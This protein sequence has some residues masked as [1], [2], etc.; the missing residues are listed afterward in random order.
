MTITT[1][2]LRALLRAAVLFTAVCIAVLVSS[3]SSAAVGVTTGSFG[4][5]QTGAAQYSISLFAPAGAG[6]MKPNLALSYSSDRSDGLAGAGFG[7]SGLSQITRCN[8]ILAANG[9]Y[10]AP[11]LSSTDQ[12]CLDGN[13]LRLTAGT[14]GAPGSR[15]QTEIE[16]FTRVT[17]YDTAGSGPAYFIAELKN[18]LI[19]EYGNSQDSRI[20]ALRVGSGQASTPRVWALNRIRDRSGNAIELTYFE[21][22]TNGGFRPDRVR[23]T[24]NTSQGVPAPYEMAFVYET[25][26]RP[27]ILYGYRFGNLSSVSG[28]VT[29][30]HRIDRVDVLHNSSVIRRYDLTY[31]A[32]GGAGARSRLQSIKECGV[33]G[34]DC[35]LPTTFTWI[36]GTPSWNAEVSTGQP[37]P[38]A[39]F[40]M[41]VNGDGRDDLVYSSS[42]ISGSGT[43][44]YMLAISAGGYATPVSTGYVNTNFAEAQPIEWDGDGRADFLV[45]YQGG[46]WW[47][48]RANG[49]G[50]DAPI[51]TGVPWSNGYQWWVA[52]VDGDGRGDLVRIDGIVNVYVRLRSGNGL[53]SSEI[54]IA[55]IEPNTGGSTLRPNAFGG[56]ATRMRSSIKQPDFD[57][58]GREDFVFKLTGTDEPDFPNPLRSTVY[59]CVV[60]SR[61]ASPAQY[62]WLSMARGGITTVGPQDWFMSDANA[63]GLTDLIW[64]QQGKALVARSRGTYIDSVSSIDIAA[65]AAPSAVAADWDG[66]GRDDLILSNTSTG[67]RW[68]SR[69]T[70][71]SMSPLVST[72][73]SGGTGN[74][75]SVGDIDGDGLPDLLRANPSGNAWLHSTHLG[76]PADVLNQATDGFGTFVNFDFASISRSNY[77]KST[78]SVGVAGPAVAAPAYP[79]RWFSGPMQVVSR[80]RA[81]NGIGGSYTVSYQYYGA[82]ANLNGRGFLGFHAVRSSDD[83]DKQFTYRYFKRDFPFTGM[84]WQQERYQPDNAT[85]IVQQTNTLQSAIL[86]ATPDNQ[87]QFPYLSETVS[88]GREVH[89]IANGNIVTQARNAYTFGD[90]FA[91]G[92]PTQITTTTTDRDAGSPFVGQAFTQTTQLH[93]NYGAASSTWCFGLPEQVTV[94]S[95]LSD[96]ASQTRTRGT[97]GAGVDYTNCRVT[98]DYIEPSSSTLAVTTTYGFDST[99]NVTSSQVVGRNWNETP[100]AARTATAQ[101]SS[102]RVFPEVTT[103]PLGQSTRFT[104]RHDL[105]QIATQTDANNL[106]IAYLYDAFGRRTRETRPDGTATTF[107][108]TACNSIN[109]RCQTADALA[110][111][112]VQA[113]ARDSTGTQVR[114]DQVIYDAF[115][116]ELYSKTP[117]ATGAASL[118]ATTYD[119]LGRVATKSA[120]YLCC[121]PHITTY[122]YDSIGRVTKTSTPIPG[123]GGTQAVSY[124][125]QGRTVNITD[126]RGTTQRVSDVLGQLRKIVDPAPGGVTLYSYDPFGNLLSATDAAGATQSWKY[127]L[128]GFRTGATVP[129]INAGTWIHRP[130]SLGELVSQTD[131]KS[132]TVTYTYDALS[133]PLTRTEPEGTT[134]WTWDTA[135]GKGIGQLASV[136]SPGYGE[137]YTYDTLGRVKTM[138]YAQDQAYQVDYAYN[139]QGSL[140]TVTYPQST[141]GYRLKVK[142]DYSFGRLTATRD[143]AS[144]T[145][146]WK[147]NALDAFSQP[148]DEQLGNGLRVLSSFDPATGWMATRRSGA[149]ASATNTQNLAYEWDISGNLNQR[150]DLRQSVTEAFRYDALHRLTDATRNGTPSLSI[151]LDA[152]GNIL[153]KSGTGYTYDS[154]YKRAL[155]SAG[156]ANYSYDANGNVVSRAGGSVSW[157]SYNLPSV[158]NGGSLSS[159]F[160]YGPDRQRWKQVATFSN[161][162]QTTI[163]VG[164]LMEK[165][166]GSAGTSF[167]HYIAAGSST[168][169]YTRRSDGTTSTFYVTDDHLGSSSTITCGT[170]VSGC[171]NGAIFVQESFDAYGARRG[172]AGSGAPSSADL[173]KFEQ[174]TRRGY[175]G[176]EMLDN[177]GLIH[178]NGRVYD[179]GLGRFLSADPFIGDGSQGLNRYSYVLNN[180]LSLVDPS[181]FRPLVKKDGRTIAIDSNGGSPNDGLDLS[182][183]WNGGGGYWDPPTCI[184][185]CREPDHS[186]STIPQ[187]SGDWLA[188]Q[189]EQTNRL[190]LSRLSRTGSVPRPSQIDS[191]PGGDCHAMIVKAPPGPGFWDTG[192]FV[193]NAL[194][195]GAWDCFMNIGTAYACNSG[196]FS[197]EGGLYAAG[198]LPFSRILGGTVKGTTAFA[199]HGLE[200]AFAGK[201]VVPKGVA[202]TLPPPGALIPDKLGRMMEAGEWEQIAAKPRYMA[203]LSGTTTH[204]PGAH[205]P[206]L[207][208]GPPVGLNTLPNSVRVTSE[209]SLS[210]LMRKTK[211]PCVWAACRDFP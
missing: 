178:M 133:R 11:T 78:S 157:T 185:P 54:R 5:S 57:G 194:G 191:C 101:Y 111:F 164:G 195:L 96:G 33:G 188:S 168:V 74:F 14:Y 46:T 144:A 182:R 82:T 149:D 9:T 162:P 121:T 159:R 24:S 52:D 34:T 199:G 8:K 26:P 107:A 86:D 65:Y 7:I 16:S 154:T 113:V 104:Y 80:Y 19:Y 143:A 109:N 91:Y 139:A 189:I 83:R 169:V 98:T 67:E 12:L 198:V 103:N 115:G 49:S 123:N 50:F 142:H 72:G 84:L 23:W 180:P 112:S 136:S 53:A 77:A 193:W 39:P 184:G 158:I 43:W 197:A 170:G 44:M 3:I 38:T 173:S 209:T 156:S 69:S 160:F 21:D 190:L 70:G 106:T 32:A 186:W 94:Q 119:A 37:V 206:N 174:A 204:L 20:E 151:K 196:K 177:L 1:E 30:T 210:A 166:F 126:A 153:S 203:I 87:R 4:V 140:D 92:N 2:R 68:V 28:Q 56:I 134:R 6:G 22:A 99:G 171:A 176:H 124:E 55:T 13:I 102:Q 95:T 179:P 122:T 40:V 15:Y 61:G 161:G 66:D 10:D 51:N 88:V 141:A 62:Y 25:E 147:L 45:P 192:G 110:K 108:I 165:V 183:D 76:V 208:L 59:L 105:G 47:V 131:P 58:D 187:D 181:G 79:D 211:G 81:S 207:L 100:L 145:V 152:A 117:L 48:L 29:E 60:L 167:R 202:I 201:T 120:P 150:Q 148:V 118:T 90:G 125:Y 42:A 18:G 63:D 27:D 35:Y 127:N 75:H 17:A 93:F 137:T 205:V 138:S 85:Q 73:V 36:N 41:D 97:P 128:L 89:G 129:V 172:S 163:Y 116:R 155:K 64:L 130:N 200:T 31:E 132:Q 135:V 71:N 175:T 114:Q 146:F